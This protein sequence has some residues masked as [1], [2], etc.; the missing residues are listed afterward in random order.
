VRFTAPNGERIR[1]STETADR[2]KAQE[3][4]DRLKAELWRTCKLG[5]KPNYTW[6]E[7]VVQWL[8]ETTHK[9]THEGDIAK[10][11]WLD[12]YLRDRP[13]EA[14]TRQE[15]QRIGEIKCQEASPA[16]ANRYLALIRSILRRAERE[17]EWLD[18][19]P[20]IR[21]YKE[22]KRRIRW[23]TR[24]QAE[25]LI[26]HL[27]PH[28]AAMVRFSLATGLRQSNVTGLTW[29]QVDLQRRVAWIHPDQAKARKAIAV[30]LNEE[31]MS[32]LRGEIGRHPERVF[33]YRGNPI[34][35]TN[36]KAW[37]AA[38]ER[39]GITDFR[40]HDLR[41]TWASWHVQAGTPLHA[42]QEMGGW[43]SPEMVRRYAHLAPEHLAEYAERIAGSGTNLTQSR[44]RAVK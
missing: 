14:I 20:A 38:L 32:V 6:N 10:L 4:Q 3:Y 21:L 41:H 42:L 27:P 26:S 33:T 8:K 15:I 36:T 44:I 17:W 11:R 2:V 18:R 24:E 29:E 39:A 19:A 16:R 7:A 5:E 37:R 31:A 25:R 28:L 40:W 22:A 23:I 34:A 43:E 13:L 35:W 1:Q 12:P 9:A 30:P